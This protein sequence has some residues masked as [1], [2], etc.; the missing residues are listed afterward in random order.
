MVGA[1]TCCHGAIRGKT[2]INRTTLDGGLRMPYRQYTL[3][4]D[5]GSTEIVW[6]RVPASAIIEWLGERP[7]LLAQGYPDRPPD[8]DT[9]NLRAW[10]PR[11]GEE[12]H[13]Y[14]ADRW[15]GPRIAETMFPVFTCTWHA[16]GSIVTKV[17]LTGT[18]GGA[19]VSRVVVGHLT[20]E[21]T[22][23]KAKTY[24]PAVDPAEVWHEIE[25]IVE[26]INEAPMG[27]A[28]GDPLITTYGDFEAFHAE[29]DLAE[30]E[31]RA[32]GLLGPEWLH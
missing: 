18:E 16:P 32:A 28:P 4:A 29:V 11:L 2:P 10:L 9:P 30:S 13:P 27:W 5:D 21:R 6:V 26:T 3:R 25:T 14:F 19:F 24:G 8:L 31:A 22:V 12:G 20:G 17:I 15:R 1:T 23:D 7:R